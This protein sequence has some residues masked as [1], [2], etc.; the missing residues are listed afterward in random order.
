MTQLLLSVP[1]EIVGSGWHPPPPHRPLGPQMLWGRDFH[2]GLEAQGRSPVCHSP[3]KGDQSDVRKKPPTKQPPL[4]DFLM[5]RS[6]PSL[7]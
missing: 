7:F 3:E 4:P 2:R 5:P 1:E 6:M